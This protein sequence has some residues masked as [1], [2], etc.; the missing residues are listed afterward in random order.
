MRYRLRIFPTYRSVTHW[1]DV[2]HCYIKGKFNPNHVLE[3]FAAYSGMETDE[4]RD[5]ILQL[6]AQDIAY[7]SHV[8]SVVLPMKWLDFKTWLTTMRIPI[9]AVD[10][11][12]LFMLCKIHDR[13]AMVFTNSKLWT[14]VKENNNL[15]LDELYTICD[16]CL[17]YLGQDLYGE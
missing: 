3:I 14:T 13:H 15:S 6:V 1:L 4:L 2:R 17:V 10:E 16:G 11:L 9:C 12:M 8:G 7:W 5:K